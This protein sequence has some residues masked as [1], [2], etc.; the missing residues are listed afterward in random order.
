MCF[1]WRRSSQ[2]SLPPMCYIKLVSVE[3]LQSGIIHFLGSLCGAPKIQTNTTTIPPPGSRL[4][5]TSFLSFFGAT[6]DAILG[7][8]KNDNEAS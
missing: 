4:F 5:S 1:Y 3:Q 2:K 8:M 7:T 6:K